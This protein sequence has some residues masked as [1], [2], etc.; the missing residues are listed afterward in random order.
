MRIKIYKTACDYLVKN[1]SIERPDLMQLINLQEEEAQFI[2][3]LD[4][5]VA[6][7]VRDWAGEKLQIEG[8]DKDYNLTLQGEYMEDIIDLFYV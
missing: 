2:A 7:K 8:F 4:E 3:E 5:V 6:C 1:L